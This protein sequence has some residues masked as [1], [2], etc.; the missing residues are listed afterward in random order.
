MILIA[1]ILAVLVICAVLWF[2]GQCSAAVC[3]CPYNC[4][5][6]PTQGTAE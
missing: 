6:H 5:E 2:G 4:P 1:A 3:E